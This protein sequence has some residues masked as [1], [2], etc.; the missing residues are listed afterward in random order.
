MQ[1]C[2]LYLESSKQSS[3]YQTRFN[4]V[5]QVLMSLEH[6]I[7]WYNA[8][9]LQFTPCTGCFGCWVKTPGRCV[10]HDDLEPV[11]ADTIAADILLVVAPVYDGFLPAIIKMCF[12]RMIPLLHPYLEIV[13][14]E[15][16]HRKRYEKYPELALILDLPVS[17]EEISNLM[18]HWAERIVLN[19]R[20]RLRAF[21]SFSEALEPEGITQLTENWQTQQYG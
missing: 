16:H 8:A 3:H 12:D 14:Q 5:R 13:N 2:C 15:V 21:L 4:Q 7:S 11:L 1:I 20:S 10:F 17:H 19:M 6:E 9:Q 18:H